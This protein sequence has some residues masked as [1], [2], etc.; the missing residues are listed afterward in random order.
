MKRSHSKAHFQREME[1]KS[2]F[3]SVHHQHQLVWTPSYSSSVPSLRQS[4][5]QMGK[6]LLFSFACFSFNST[7]NQPKIFGAILCN[8][9]CLLGAN[10]SNG[11]W[12]VQRTALFLFMVNPSRLFCQKNCS[13]WAYCLLDRSIS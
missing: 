4:I 6:R 13:Q 2:S 9:A 3:F 11:F 12:M 1:K 5:L 10:V 7:I 8:K